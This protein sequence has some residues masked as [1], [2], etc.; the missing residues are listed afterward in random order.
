MCLS[1]FFFFNISTYLHILKPK[2]IYRLMEKSFITV[3][4]WFNKKTWWV[5]KSGS[6]KW[7]FHVMWPKQIHQKLIIFSLF[8][9]FFILSIIIIG[10]NYN[11]N[12]SSSKK[13]WTISYGYKFDLIGHFNFWILNSKK[14]L[15]IFKILWTK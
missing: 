6:D 11:V 15:I 9:F 5:V 8:F 10:N 4:S 14:F 1:R 7:N 3:S 2:I 13:W 12:F